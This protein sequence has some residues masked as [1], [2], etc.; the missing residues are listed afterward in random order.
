MRRV[1]STPR[2]LVVTLD[3]CDSLNFGDARLTVLTTCGSVVEDLLFRETLGA[4]YA[5]VETP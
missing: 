3:Y 4:W 1:S 2:E 5:H